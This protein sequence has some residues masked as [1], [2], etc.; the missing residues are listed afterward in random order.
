MMFHHLVVGRRAKKNAHRIDQIAT[1]LYTGLRTSAYLNDLI[2][3]QL[4]L[5]LAHG[6]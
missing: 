4:T 2:N 6:I 1:E 3:G 5:G